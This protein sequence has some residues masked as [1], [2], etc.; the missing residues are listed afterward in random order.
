MAAAL[1]LVH[2]IDHTE[3]FM[4]R[5]FTEEFVSRLEAIN[6]VSRELRAQGY[7]TV[8][9]IMGQG[10]AMPTIEVQPG[11]NMQAKPL[12]DLGCGHMLEKRPDG[13]FIRSITRHGVIVMWREGAAQ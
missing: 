1:H 5:I 8:R 6:R 2:S 4:S 10:R 3:S 12:L 9:E 11:T 7:R 13:S